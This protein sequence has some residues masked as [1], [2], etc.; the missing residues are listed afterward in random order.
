MKK[1]WKDYLFVSMQFFLFGL[2][3]FEFFPVYEFPGFLRYFGLG[4]AVIGVIVFIFSVFQLNKNLTAFP[5]PVK[6]SKLITSGMYNFSRHPIYSGIILFLFGYGFFNN[7]ISK[8]I[9][10]VV[11]T[12]L[13]YLK[14]KYEEEQ[15][16]QKFPEYK[17]YKE[18][19]NRFFSAI[20]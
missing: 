4:T 15:L 19:V 1:S 11:L 17:D 6:G 8:L 16:L 13:F 12:S 7:S 10:A 5:T 18:K 3:A 2:Y 9:L 20:R 14:T